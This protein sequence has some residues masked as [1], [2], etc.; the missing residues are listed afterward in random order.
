MYI[1]HYD[2]KV[3]RKPHYLKDHVREMKEMLK[4]FNLTFDLYGMTEVSVILHDLGK[5]S[6]RFQDYVQDPHGKR[7]SVKHAIAGAFVLSNKNDRLNVQ[8]RFFSEL[9][10]LIVAGHHTGLADRNKLFFDKYKDLPT[11]LKGIEKLATEE[12]EESLLILD[13]TPSLSIVEKVGDERFSLYIS[14]LVRFVMSALVDADYLNTEAYFSTEKERMRL[15]ETPSF[16]AVQQSLDTYISNNFSDKEDGDRVLNHLK[17]QVQKEAYEF[18]QKE[19]SFYTLHAPTGTGKTIAALQFALNHAKHRNKSRIITALPLM[20]LTEEISSIYRDIFGF[21]HVIEDH[22]SISVEDFTDEDYTPIRLA[23]ENWNRPIV[24]ST[25]VQ[26]FESLFHHRPMKLRKLHRLANSIIILDEYHKL[27]HHVLEPILQ[28]LDVLQTHFNVTVLLMSATPY[29]FFE[30][31]EIDKMNLLNKPIEITNYEELFRKV[32]SRVMYEWVEV[33]LSLQKLSIRMANEIAVLTIVNTRKEAQ[34]LHRLLE[35]ENHRFEKVYYVSTT[36]CSAHRERVLKEIK[37]KR[38]PNNPRPIAV[39]STSIL[40]SG[41]DTSFPVVYRMLAPLDAIVQAAGRC[42][43]YGEVKKGRVII[44][45]NIEKIKVENSY[46]A[47]INQTKYLLKTKGVNAFTEPDSFIT[48]YKRMFNEE[49]NKFDIRAENCLNFSRI[50]QDFKMIE[51]NRIS[52][53]CPMVDGF[54]EEWMDESK[55]PRWWRKIQPYTVAV[56][57]YSSDYEKSGDVNIW[58][59]EYDRTYG[60]VL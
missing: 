33:P 16:S 44:F 36:M 45:E 4:T 53:V 49:L 50:S 7:G 41:I 13:G 52:V 18:G 47:G 25:T 57:L 54:K 10:Q 40:E 5:K 35:G 21:E 2:H 27:P 56:S 31:K 1:A 8:E 32:P 58:K 48:Y 38:D 19:D 39:V 51:D 34:Q 24:V 46:Q 23:A 9:I 42:N 17:W 30:S 43:R 14:T 15:Y 12:V 20:N 37:S 29:P 6:R 60:I 26:L 3:K 28:Q 22:S 11:E 55:S 59:G